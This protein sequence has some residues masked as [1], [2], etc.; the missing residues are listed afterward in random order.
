MESDVQVGQVTAILPLCPFPPLHWWYLALGHHGGIACIDPDDVYQKQTLRN[1]ISIA[2]PNGHLMIPIPVEGNFQNMRTLDVGLSSHIRPVHSWRTIQ[3][4]YGGSPYYDL[5][6]DELRE[7]WFNF[8][9]DFPDSEKKLGHFS[10]AG[11]EWVSELCHWT[12]PPFL[13]KTPDDAGE[14]LDL[15]KKLALKGNNWSFHRYTQLQEPRWG[16]ISNLSV[17]DAL[18]MIGPNE[19]NR[20]LRTLVS[21]KDLNSHLKP[22]G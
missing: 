5:L 19:L 6:K 18:F 12:L 22:K 3:T 2:G 15:R 13:Q 7:I 8:L 9:P 14:L 4:A 20:Q 17:L 10:M 16:F 11:L 1:R 21:P